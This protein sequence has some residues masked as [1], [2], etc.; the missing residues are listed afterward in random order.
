MHLHTYGA[1]GEVT[2]SCHLLESG[3]Q[4]VLLD[5]GLIQGRPVDEVRN[6]DRF[7]FDPKQLTAVVLS[8]AHIDH[9][10]RLP[11]LVK[12]GFRGPI[13]AHPATR[14]LCRIMLRD[15][16]FLQEKDAEAE[17]RKRERK[18]M[19]P[20]AALYD[21]ADVRRTLRLFQPLDYAV[22]TEVAPGIEVRLFD[23]GHILGSSIVECF[24]SAHGIT[25][26][27]VYSGDLG[28][29]ENTLLRDPALV[30]SA[31]LLLL[32][33]TY[34]DR[35]HRPQAETLAEVKAVMNAALNAGG[36]VLIPAFAVGRTQ[37]LLYLFSRYYED[38]QL[39]RWQIF[40]DS[41]LAIDATEVYLRH[42]DLLDPQVL[43]N[44][45]LDQASQL[46]NLRLTRTPA[47]SMAI[48]RIRDGAIVIAGSGMCNGGRIR[49]HLKHNV[50]RR[51]CH[52]IMVGYQAQG[53]LGRQLVD[54]AKH[55]RLWGEAIQVNAQVH[56]IGGFSAHADQSGLLHWYQQFRGRPP[57]A[58]VHGEARAQAALAEKLRGLGAAVDIARQGAGYD[59]NTGRPLPR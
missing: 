19:K 36:N 26:K 47:Q 52:I 41:P 44:F 14:D 21:L 37:D 43:A 50:W 59:L 22:K 45:D 5:C 10:G 20:V 34:G 8:H 4:R 32:E 29:P 56:T 58:L 25:R 35:N 49:H 28:Y 46:P 42:R 16:A 9:S 6:R 23:A 38:W 7:P 18:G 48:N 57:V 40:L 30:E 33:S 31:D 1:A 2:G 51:G 24:V 54:G 15:S 12:A 11:L 55:I 17:N 53:T 13:Y 27:L 3:G 39:A